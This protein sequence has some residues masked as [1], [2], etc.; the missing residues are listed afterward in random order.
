MAAKTVRNCHIVLHR[1]LSDAERLGLVPRNAAHAAKA[2]T[3]RREETVTWTA[4]GLSQFLTQVATDRMYAAYVVLATTRMRRGE[5]LGLR[6]S[7]MDLDARGLSVAQTLTTIGDQL[8]FGPTKTD[9]SRRRVALDAETAK[10][11]RSHRARQLEERLVAGE[12]WDGGNDLVFREADSRPIHPDRFTTAFK[13]HDRAA[14]RAGLEVEVQPVLRA[15][16]P[17]R[18]VDEQGPVPW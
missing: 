1:A 3:G 14:V 12:L 18:M 7:D 16:D 8:L 6:W 2:P 9:R 4:E 10:A 5:V 15:F 13:R 11:L 17:R